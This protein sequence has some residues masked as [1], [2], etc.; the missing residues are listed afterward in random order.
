MKRSNQ[1]FQ[2]DAEPIYAESDEGG[3]ESMANW[4]EVVA[5][6]AIGGVVGSSAQFLADR[7]ASG[8]KRQMALGM[9]AA[10]SGVLGLGLKIWSLTSG[11]AFPAW[12][13]DVGDPLLTSGA[14]LGSMAGMRAIDNSMQV[15][16]PATVPVATVDPTVYDA[17]VA[18]GYVPAGLPEV[19]PTPG[20][21]GYQV[22][23]AQFALIDAN[24]PETYDETTGLWD[25]TAAS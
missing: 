25:E 2:R 9:T 24:I 11:N 18:A 13:D 16:Q 6:V 10:A 21:P 23:Q 14:V 12:Q 8:Q 17:A 4:Q 5:D 15:T 22:D 19:D 7:W 3:A 20:N 1:V